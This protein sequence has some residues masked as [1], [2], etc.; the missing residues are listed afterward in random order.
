[1]A[2]SARTGPTFRS[3]SRI[4][5]RRK[6][7]GRHRSRRV[8]S[9]TL[10][11]TPTMPFF[12]VDEIARRS[13]LFGAKVQM[14]PPSSAQ[15]AADPH[16]V[17]FPEYFLANINFFCKPFSQTSEPPPSLKLSANPHPASPTARPGESLIPGTTHRRRI[18][19]SGAQAAMYRTLRAKMWTRLLRR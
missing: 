4:S 3:A 18:A 7:R 8:C 12:N 15:Y 14:N 2:P 16:L 6:R 10:P 17:R 13:G 11:D 19:G 1:M 5:R 9:R